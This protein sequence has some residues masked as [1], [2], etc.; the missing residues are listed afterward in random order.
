MLEEIDGLK[1]KLRR[2][3][4]ARRQLF[5][6]HPGAELGMAAVSLGGGSQV[7]SLSPSHVTKAVFFSVAVP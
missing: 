2:D 1:G 5:A 4:S 7:V 3:A 6:Y